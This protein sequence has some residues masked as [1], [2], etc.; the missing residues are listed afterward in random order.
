GATAPVGA[1]IGVIAEPDED[2]SALLAEAPAGAGEPTHAA[3]AREPQAGEADKTEQAQ[4]TTGA[5]AAVESPD[6]RPTP[7]PAGVEPARAAGGEARPVAAAPVDG[8]TKASPLAK[9]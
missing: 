9:R 5:Q 2:I 7:T 3:P 1:V 8:R 6:R 4:A